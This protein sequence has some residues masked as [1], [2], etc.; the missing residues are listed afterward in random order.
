MVCG[1]RGAVVG[2]VAFRAKGR[3][4]KS[5]RGC[6]AHPAE[7]PDLAPGWPM[8][9]DTYYSPYLDQKTKNVK[10]SIITS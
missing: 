3:G 10:I 7:A 2:I 6:F 1:L 8:H 4:F 5:T 9:L